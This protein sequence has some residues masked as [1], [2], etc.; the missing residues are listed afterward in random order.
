[1]QQESVIRIADNS[2]GKRA[3]VIRV[4]GLEALVRVTLVYPSKKIKKGQL[5]TA[6]IIGLKKKNPRRSGVTVCS[7]NNDLILLKKDKTPLSTRVYRPIFLELRYSGLSRVCSIA[8]SI[9]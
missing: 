1:M 6:C 7:L 4:K 2:G 5:F 3:A 9:Y 8:R